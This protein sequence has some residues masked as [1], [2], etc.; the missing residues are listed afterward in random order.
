M[1]DN[2]DILTQVEI[3]A[4]PL[5]SISDLDPLIE[6][7]GTTRYALLGEASHGTHEYYSWRSSISKRLIL[8]KGFQFIAVEGDWPDCYTINR[9]IKGYPDSGKSAY[10]VLYSFSRWPTW[11]WANREIEELVEWLKEYNQSVPTP[12][13]VGFYGLDVYSLW[14]SMR[15]IITYVKEH[16]PEMLDTAIDAYLCFEPY[17]EDVEAYAQSTAFVSKSC[18]DEV[19]QLLQEMQQRGQKKRTGE[20]K[21]EQFN[22]EQNA[23]VAKNAEHYYRTM[24]GGGTQSWNIRDM[25]MVETLERLV[26]FHGVNSKGIVW[27]HN[28]HVGD[29]RYTDMAEVGMVNVGQLVRQTHRLTE[30]G[31]VGFGS[32]KGTVIAGS[33]W[34]A[35]MQK[36]NVPPARRESW[37]EVLHRASAV[38]KLL[39]FSDQDAVGEMMA[40]RGHRAIGV[41]YNPAHELGNYV[42]TVLP[43]R[44]DAFLYFDRTRALRPIHIEEVTREEVPETYPSAV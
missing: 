27:A 10:E 13:K 40:M 26:K 34:G 1:A 41:V 36:M 17:Q 23:L 12:R 14:E 28:T 19:I 44:Y 8:E 5:R 33:R 42:P 25:H 38:N 2:Q 37:E 22:V 39:F 24:L 16:D 7:L 29:A 18:E 15:E 30:V 31:I 20:K 11:M 43:K 32:Y 6:L 21:E 35:A 9:Y 3:N 4:S